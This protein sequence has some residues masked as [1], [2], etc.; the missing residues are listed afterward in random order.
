MKTKSKNKQ[1]ISLL[2][3][4]ITIIVMIILAAAIIL[5]LSSNGIID[6]AN[7]AV[8]KTDEK[9]MQALA[10]TLWAE[11]YLDYREGKINEN[12]LIQ[13]V[14][15]GLRE[16]DKDYLLKYDVKISSQGVNLEKDKSVWV[17]MGDAKTLS[18]TENIY[19][20]F[21]GYPVMEN[22]S[23]RVT[24]ACSYYE[25]T[26][27]VNTIAQ[28]DMGLWYWAFNVKENGDIITITNKIEFD[29]Y[30]EQYTNGTLDGEIWLNNYVQTSVYS[31]RIDEE[32]SF[33]VNKVEIKLPE[34]TKKIYEG[35]DKII[36]DEPINIEGLGIGR[37]Y[38][39]ELR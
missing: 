26:T 37:N 39:I 3:L 27:L 35:K 21:P 29:D 10:Q 16:A 8:D 30:M 23:Y 24:V 11:A 38:L 6:R 15:S 19:S 22:M 4:V 14:N 5:S 13:R 25:V 2:V 9:Q 17:G 36:F 34:N 12:T 18:Y 31:S 28:D 33:A 1:G 7:E 32:K 20:I